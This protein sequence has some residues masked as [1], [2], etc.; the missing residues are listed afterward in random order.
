MYFFHHHHFFKLQTTSAKS[1]TGVSDQITKQ[2]NLV[3]ELK[4]SKA[5][6]GKIDAAVKELLSL[7]AEYKSLTGS[8][9]TPGN[10]AGTTVT[11]PEANTAATMADNGV[12][13][14]L[15]DKVNAQANAVRTLK[16]NGSGKADID[17]AVKLLLDLKLEYKNATGEEFPA[18]SGRA[19]SKKPAAKKPEKPAPAPSQSN[20]SDGKDGGLKK[21]TRLGLEATKEGNLPEW[22]SQVLTKGELIEYYDVSGCYILRHWSFAIWKQI[23]KWFTNEIDKLG[24]KEVYFP[25]FVSK[26]ALEKEKEHIADFSPEVAWVTKSG[27]SELSEPVAIRPTSET[28]MYPAFAKWVQ[29]YR[30]L[31]IRINQW[32][33]VVR[34]EFKHPQPFLRTR[35][36][37]WQEGHT[38]Y[39]N[40]EDA[41]EEVL[42][43]LG[44]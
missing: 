39:A 19:P 34:W 4:T 29:S 30:D 24:V 3:R 25:L 16:S 10:T 2:G 40:A 26:A 13:T 41:K 12:K 1:A 31:P 15:T 7:K 33:N 17:A 32:S 11:K 8:D 38:A 21:Q 36:F 9:W 18:P 22:Y 23:Q 5:D 6:K 42:T 35:E 37:L 20:I 44:E 28:V 43:I 14:A 27:E